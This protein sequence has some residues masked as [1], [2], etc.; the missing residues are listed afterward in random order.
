MLKAGL[1]LRY[2]RIVS[3]PPPAIAGQFPPSPSPALPLAPHTGA[4]GG[5]GAKRGGGRGA[6][7]ALGADGRKGDISGAIVQPHY[8]S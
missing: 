4:V 7:L 8:S 1:D 6:W 5:G 2:P 3:V